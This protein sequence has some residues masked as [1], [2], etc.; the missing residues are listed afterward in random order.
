MILYKLVFAHQGGGEKHLD[1]IARMLRISG[2]H[3][4]HAEI[5]AWVNRM[6][7]HAEWLM[8]TERFQALGR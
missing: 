7:L 6:G 8:A 3:V 2:E 5:A 4:S 1:D